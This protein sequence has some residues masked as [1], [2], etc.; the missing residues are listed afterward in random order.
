ML[1]AIIAGLL[2]GLALLSPPSWAA[3]NAAEAMNLSGMQR[4]LSQRIAKTYL[5]IGAEVRPDR[6]EQQL[7]QSIAKFESNYLALGEYAPTAPIRSALEHAGKTWQR[8]RELALSRPDKQQALVILELS[9][10]LLAQ[11]EQVVQLLER[12]SGG[13]SAR[14][15][16]RS[17]RQRMLSQRI[18][19]LYLAMSWRLPVAGLEQSFNQA[20]DEFDQALQ[21]LQQARQNTPA[22]AKG[23]QQAE[24]QWRFTRA[25]FNLSN[26]SRFVPTVIATTSETL[27]WQMN[28]LTSQYEG[29]M[30][31]GS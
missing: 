24:A 30:Q 29:V 28:E 26:D 3:I 15:V 5:M 20:V 9:D 18:A 21:E 1:N 4:M 12:H 11:S 23:L 2:F 31:A 10:Q 8:Y 16:N 7:D 6:A 13:Q 27:L 17:G 22:I 14:L 25:G 19:K